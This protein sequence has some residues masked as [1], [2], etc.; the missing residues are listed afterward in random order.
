M[1]IKV[2]RKPGNTT[3]LWSCTSLVCHLSARV[4]L[5]VKFINTP[6]NNSLNQSLFPCWC[7]KSARFLWLIHKQTQTL[8][9]SSLCQRPVTPAEVFIQTHAFILF[10]PL[11]FPCSL[12]LPF[13]HLH[14]YPSLQASVSSFSLSLSPNKRQSRMDAPFICISI[15]FWWKMEWSLK[16]H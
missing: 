1:S 12:R 6:P 14:L 15:M 13:P 2:Q 9:S 3:L 4:E 11:W 8:S 7:L 16:M 10:I 5:S